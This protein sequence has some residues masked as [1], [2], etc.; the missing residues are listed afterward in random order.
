M[1]KPQ[2]SINT[3][4]ETK[5][6]HDVQEHALATNS[7]YKCTKYIHLLSHTFTSASKTS[8]RNKAAKRQINAHRTSTSNRIFIILLT[9]YASHIHPQRGTSRNYNSAFL[10]SPRHITALHK[11]PLSLSKESRS[12]ARSQV[13]STHQGRHLYR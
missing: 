8:R 2:S 9:H 5:G 11:A 7:N 6:H 3:A 4:R 13:V 10:T 1:I 12:S